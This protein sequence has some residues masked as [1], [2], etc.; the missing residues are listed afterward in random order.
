MKQKKKSFQK[1]VLKSSVKN[2][3]KWH[4]TDLF[5]VFS[6][7]VFMLFIYVYVIYKV[8]KA[9][10]SKIDWIS[11]ATAW[12]DCFHNIYKLKLKNNAFTNLPNT[13]LYQRYKNI[14]IYQ[15]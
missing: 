6:I 4:D 9:A 1:E 14:Y 12:Q 7:Y 13:K 15:I 2:K 3:H 10:G 11:D 5:H 8:R